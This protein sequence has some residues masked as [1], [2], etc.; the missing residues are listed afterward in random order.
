[1]PIWFGVLYECFGFTSHAQVKT[2][3]H[4][5]VYIYK[6]IYIYVGAWTC[7]NCQNTPSAI[8]AAS[9][10]SKLAS[11]ETFVK[12]PRNNNQDLVN[13]IRLLRTE[14]GNLKQK[15]ASGNQHN[16]ELKKLIA[17][18]ACYWSRCPRSRRKHAESVRCPR[19]PGRWSD[20]T[21]T[22]NDKPTPA[23]TPCKKTHPK[24]ND[25]HDCGQFYCPW[26]GASRAWQRLWCFW[27]CVSRQ[28]C[29][30][31]QRSDQTYHPSC[32]VTVLAAGTNNID[33]QPLGQYKEE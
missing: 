20:R 28:N 29:T 16:S 18:V 14:N 25:C 4:I 1:M 32:D 5:H 31:D 30:T 3:E 6:Y 9:M 26:S 23:A 10:Q 24:A 22:G 17:T 8:T 11:I 27:V 21:H 13:E 33:S 7:K 2:S 19:C 12:G 15:L